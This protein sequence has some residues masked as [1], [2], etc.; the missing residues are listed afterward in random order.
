MLVTFNKVVSKF[1]SVHGLA[2]RLGPALW[3]NLKFPVELKL[4][5][6]CNKPYVN[7]FGYK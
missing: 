3:V 5:Q 4:G 6:K 1:L 2:K 7:Y